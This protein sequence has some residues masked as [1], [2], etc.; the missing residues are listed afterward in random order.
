M[1]DFNLQ[2]PPALRIHV[3]R[4]YPQA[5]SFNLSLAPIGMAGPDHRIGDTVRKRWK[6]QSVAM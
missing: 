6:D 3:Q 2:K 5:L 4:H 1:Y